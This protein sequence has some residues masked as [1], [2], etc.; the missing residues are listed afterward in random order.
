MG[1]F[2]RIDRETLINNT[3]NATAW[4]TLGCS[5][6]PSEDGPTC[7]QTHIPM[8]NLFELVP[9]NCKDIFKCNYCDCN[10]DDID[11]I[12]QLMDELESKYCIDRSRIYVMGFSNGA[13]MT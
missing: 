13:Q 5:G 3:W 9:D 1:I 6:S 2:W 12:D 10:I 8:D 4:N 7:S 11:F